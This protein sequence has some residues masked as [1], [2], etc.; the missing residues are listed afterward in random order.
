MVKWE[1]FPLTM[2]G[3]CSVCVTCVCMCV[4]VYARVC[5]ICHSSYYAHPKIT[6]IVSIIY[7]YSLRHF[8]CIMVH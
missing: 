7:Y 6:I 4:C 8:T 3:Y 5:V 2:C 1:Y